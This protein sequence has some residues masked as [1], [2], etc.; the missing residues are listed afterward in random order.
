MRIAITMCHGLSGEGNTPLSRDH[1]DRLMGIAA[2]MGFRSITYDDLAAW[3]AGAITLPPRPMMIDVDHPAKSVRHGVMEALD[4]YGFHG[5]LFINTGPLEDMYKSPLRTL[6][7]R[8]FMT[9]EEIGE[10]VEAGWRI[11][12]HTH[13]HPDLSALSAEDSNGEKL[14]AELEKNDEMLEA[15]LGVR[16]KD[17]AFTGTSWS[18]TAEKEVKKRYRFGRLWIV[19]PTY[20]ADGKDVRYAELVAVPG[21]DEADGG[22]PHAA[23][24]IT[25]GTDAYRL[26]S[27]EI[28]ALIYAPEAFRAYLRGALLE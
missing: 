2:E 3:R 7:E 22:P 27:M 15:N 9:W 10:L 20:K 26:P 13:T 5:N 23:R 1:L 12:A 17:F 11:G 16:P 8:E 6:R 19:G 25:R 4:R 24:Y 28:Q 21:N 14:R 18:S